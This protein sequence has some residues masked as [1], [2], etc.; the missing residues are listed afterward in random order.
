MTGTSNA[1]EGFLLLTLPNVRVSAPSAN[2]PEQTGVLGLECVTIPI[3]KTDPNS[4]VTAGGSGERDVWLVMKLNYWE[5]LVSPID[6][7]RHSRQHRTF[8]FKAPEGP[9]VLTLAE[10]ENLAQKEDIES[11]EVLLSQYGVLQELDDPS[12]KGVTGDDRDLKGHLVLVDEEDGKV[13]GT[14]GDQ[15]HVI[16][17]PSVELDSKA[18]VVMDMPEEGQT[19]LLM[20]SANLEEQDGV[21][22]SAAY[23][24]RGIV[25]ATDLLGKGMTVASDYYVRNSTPAP[26]PVVFSDSTRN[27]LRRVHNVSGQAV[28]V[29]QTTTNMIFAMVDKAFDKVSGATQN[30]RSQPRSNTMLAQGSMG[31]P[32]PTQ[33]GKEEG[34]TMDNQA[35]F[36][37]AGQPSPPK[38]KQRLLNRLLMSTDL[39]FTT[40]ESSAQNLLT[41]GNDKLAV[42]LGHKYGSDVEGAV[43]HVGGAVRNVGVVYIDCRGVGRRVMIRKIGKRVIKGTINGR[44]GKKDAQ[45]IIGDEALYQPAPS[46]TMPQ[47]QSSAHD[48]KGPTAPSSARWRYQGNEDT[49]TSALPEGHAGSI[50]YKA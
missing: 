17:D 14:L 31:I 7:I 34:R 42:S 48:L 21:L 26:T 16:E 19:E 8:L 11:F 24:S 1:P 6:P 46:A 13:V 28:K 9:V 43:R 41:H 4:Y 12:D 22:K 2:P 5:L 3:P 50:P 36:H 20:H 33:S 39:I 10:P 15:Y 27:S 49:N 30:Q 37:P 45:V 38:K 29:T 40:L 44:N 35:A 32:E 18:P 47:G 25:F 23:V